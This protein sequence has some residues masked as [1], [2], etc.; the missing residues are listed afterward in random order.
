M[1]VAI[2]LFILLLVGPAFIKFSAEGPGSLYAPIGISLTF[3][4]IAGFIAQ[5]L[6]PLEAS[7]LGVYVH[8]RSGDSAAEYKGEYGLLAGDI[9]EGLIYTMKEMAQKYKK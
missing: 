4:L 1:A 2:G 7:R 5:G 8:G 3:A 9:V 6:S